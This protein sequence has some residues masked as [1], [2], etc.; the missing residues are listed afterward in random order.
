VS[1]AGTGA[2]SE[3][4]TGAVSE[5]GTGAPGE[6]AGEPDE[7]G[8]L[9]ARVADLE[10]RLREHGIDPDEPGEAPAATG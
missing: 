5:A 4:G 1:E 7:L 6:G 3:A 2:V 9:R 10:A 8:R